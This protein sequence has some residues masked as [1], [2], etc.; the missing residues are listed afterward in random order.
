MQNN[1]SLKSYVVEGFRHINEA[2]GEAKKKS[3][4]EFIL[5]IKKALGDAVEKN[6]FSGAVGEKQKKNIVKAATPFVKP[7]NSDLEVKSVTRHSGSAKTWEIKVIEAGVNF[8]GNKEEDS[9]ARTLHLPGRFYYSYQERMDA[10]KRT[11]LGILCY[12]IVYGLQ[13]P[14]DGKFDSNKVDEVLS[15]SKYSNELWSK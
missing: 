10:E 9:Y 2:S 13:I 6:N 7:V 3:V 1:K 4:D 8:M 15:K 12:E 11:M 14:F 5:T